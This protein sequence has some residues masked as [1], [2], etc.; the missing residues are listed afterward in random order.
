MTAKKNKSIWLRFLLPGALIVGALL[1]VL[2]HF[3]FHSKDEW[4]GELLSSLGEALFIAGLLGYCVDG[5]LKTALVKDVAGLVMKTLWGTNAPQEYVEK[6]RDSIGSI[7]RMSSTVEIGIE[8]SWHEPGEILK[9]RCTTRSI[10]HNISRSS[11][12]ASA[13]WL[14][15]T[16]DGVPNSE[17]EDFEVTVTEPAIGD[18]VAVNHR[19]SWNADQ[20]R[21]FVQMK[22]DGSATLREDFI[23][24]SS[25]PEIPPA[26]IC[27]SRLIGTTYHRAIGD[28]PLILSVPALS[29]AIKIGGPALKDLDFRARIGAD[30][31]R[32]VPTGESLKG[33]HGFAHAGIAV[34]LEWC[35]MGESARAHASDGVPQARMEHPEEKTGHQ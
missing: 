30:E 24:T 16:I 15:H 31:L 2:V 22:E 1:I 19:E 14:G 17:I 7:D 5:V 28:Q 11:W 26:G 25:L 35:P 21:P 3:T 10:K 4:H 20:L 6:L 8:L 18:R 12:G 29:V 33:E 9:A 13:P 23:S 34:W 32:L 27:E